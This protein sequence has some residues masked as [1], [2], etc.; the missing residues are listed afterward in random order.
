MARI[1]ILGGGFG[2]LTV[3]TELGRRLGG[4]HEVVLIDRNEQFMMG[5]RKLWAIVGLGTL[6][7]GRRSRGRLAGEGVRF[8]QRE[9]VRIDPAARR[10]TTD[11]ETL[12]ATVLVV[13]LGAE[14]RPDLVSGLAEH[15]H[16]VYDVAAVPG[17][18]RAIAG[19]D[20][21]RIAIVIAGVP[22]RCPPAP[23]ECAMLLDAHL[24]ERGIRDR[25]TL[26][27]TTLQPM[28]LPNAGRAGSD[29]LA[30]QLAARDIAFEVGRKVERV[31]V[32]RVVYADTQLEADVLIGVPPHRPPRVV[33]ESG[34]TGD[35]EW[36]TVDPATLATGFAN[37]Y[38]IGDNTHITLA[39]NLP[40]PKAGIFAELEG[41]RVAAAIV[42]S[43]AGEPEPPPFDGKGYCFIEM[44][45]DEATLVEGDFFARPEP[46]VAVGAVSAEH[47]AAK[48]RFESERLVRWFGG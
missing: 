11:Q 47:R 42:A 29:W 13:A 44:G 41:Q 30:N 33:R 46:Q 3:A 6:A 36:I 48:Q 23:Y 28:L 18:E 9:I 45:G 20:N 10:V 26:T 38:A 14:P 15:A 19:F 43:L 37:V 21:G 24:R 5:L 12:E 2:G 4:E 27:I 32:G 34:L 1:V 7:E 39:N 40:L 25:T 16:D 8:L 22:Y 35:G 17:L 31:E